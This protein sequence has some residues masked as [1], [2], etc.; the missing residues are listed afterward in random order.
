V[1]LATVVGAAWW[2]HRGPAAVRPNV[3]LV[4]IDSLRSDHLHSYGY[5]RATSPTIDRLAAGGTRFET[6]V[7]PASWTLPSHMTLLTAKP[8]SEHGVTSNDQ[9]LKPGTVTLAE[10]FRRAGYATAGFVA[11]PYLLSMYGF[12]QGFDL[13]DDSIAQVPRFESLKGVTSPKSVALITRY[14]EDW[15]KGGRRKPFFVFFH[16]WDVHFD[17]NP[18]PPY[19]SM[20][21]P[22]YEG[23]VTGVLLDRSINRNMNPRDLAHVV[24]LYDGE[25]RY[26]DEHLGEVLETLRKLGILDDTIVVVTA[27]HGEEFFEHGRKGHGQA[28]YDE[29]LLVPLV[30][31]YPRAVAAGRVVSD[32]V[33]L[34]DVAP[35]VLELAGVPAPAGFGTPPGTKYGAVSVAS[36][37]RPED[38]AAEAPSLLA[39]SRTTMGKYTRTSVRTEGAKLILRSPG[40]MRVKYFDLRRDPDEKT[41]LSD[42]PAVAGSAQKLGLTLLSWLG[43]WN[44]QPKFASPLDLPAS[45]ADRL[46]ALGYI[47]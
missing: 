27:D 39:F 4:S 12:D 34:M 45:Q 22:D 3:L 30:I 29:T 38:D 21:D 23:N 20:F 2:T 7:A 31:R 46:R 40:P 33:R 8:P 10:A 9:R 6:V 18:P 26:T 16:L 41:N 13:Y 14:L 36:A 44:A 1:G 5:E 24:A 35:T 47:Q 43:H 25:I 42:D 11:A 19:D 32:Q 37:L 17:Y 28:L 15:S